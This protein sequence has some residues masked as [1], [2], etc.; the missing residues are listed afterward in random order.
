MSV[1]VAVN[2]LVRP[3]ARRVSPGTGWRVGGFMLLSLIVS[4]AILCFVPAEEKKLA[5]HGAGRAV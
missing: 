3:Y 1:Q 4:A 5:V 2:T